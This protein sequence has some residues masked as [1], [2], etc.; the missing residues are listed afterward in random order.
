[1]SEEDIKR[2]FITPALEAQWERGNITMEEQ[3]RAPITD[4]EIVI[5]GTSAERKA[6]KKADYM[7][8]MN[9]DQPIA[10]VEAK[11]NRHSVSSGLQQAMEYAQMIRVPFAYSSNGDTF[12]E[13]D[14]LTGTENQIALESFPSPAE[15]WMRYRNGANNGKGLTEKEIA[16]YNQPF[17]SSQ[18]TYPLRYYQR[19]A[20][21]NVFEAIAKGRRRILLVMATGT[22]KT[23]TAFQIVW[24]LLQM[25]AVKK[26]LYL[27]DRNVLVDQSIEQDFSP[28][29]KVIHKVDFS[30]DDASTITSYQ[31]YFS[32]YQQ[33]D[34]SED[35]TEHYRELFAP[36]FFDLIIVDEC[37]RGSAKE[38]GRWRKI[39]DYFTQAIHLGMTATPKETDDVSNIYYFNE[40]VYTYSLKQGIEDGFLAPFKV[41]KVRLNISDGWRPYKDQKDLDGNLI[42]DRMYTNSDFDYNIILKDRTRE[43]ADAI[44]RYLMATDRMQKTIVF[45]PTEE[46][47]ER[48][49]IELNNLNRDMVQK[50]P[51]YVVRITGT[52]DYGKGKLRY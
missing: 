8:F 4:G 35:D 48:M 49:R 31:V 13:H 43:V 23:L 1:M 15:L 2:L 30:K 52:D 10:I 26:V 42:P 19:N 24:R 12:M 29:E 22:G 14:F 40:P 7:L 6:P 32:L 38:N 20:V 27:A 36:D 25:G 37:H 47:A 41:F 51:D 39:L 33:L 34:G 3:I 9:R 45:C 50:N 21:N 44:T 16:S 11:D 5:K 28:L 46:A 17:F 18:N